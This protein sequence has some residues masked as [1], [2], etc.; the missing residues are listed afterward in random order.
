MILLACFLAIT[1]SEAGFK[2]TP[3]QER[4]TWQ[5]MRKT[6]QDARGL[7]R[8][9]AIF[10]VLLAIGLFYGL[11]SEGLDRLWAPH[12]LQNFQAPWLAE[13]RSVV[14]F[15][16]IRAVAVL[17][18]LAATEFVRRQVN[19]DN[20]SATGYALLWDAAGIILALAGFALT[21][22]FWVALGFYWLVDLLRSVIDP[23]YTAWFNSYV[24][25]P[26]VRATMF[27]VGSQVDAVGQIAGG[28]LV[29]AIGNISIRAALAA[30]A[31]I[32]LPVLPLYGETIRRGV[33]SR[34]ADHPTS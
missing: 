34:P 25:D 14:W 30:S 27:S 17:A 2:P 7:M 31:L 15:G 5:M 11:Y 24:D 3:P 6:L 32:L 10:V 9:Q 21:R 20:P 29:G 16:A 26:Q 12:L 8:R 28:P 33:R 13:A 22:H 18:S 23:L 1:M 19:T 4:Q